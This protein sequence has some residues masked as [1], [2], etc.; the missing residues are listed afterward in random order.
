MKTAAAFGLAAT[1]M[2][3]AA[4]AQTADTPAPA[5]TPQPLGDITGTWAV[6][7]AGLTDTGAVISFTGAIDVA[8][9]GEG[10]WDVSLANYVL[11]TQSQ[12]PSLVNARQACEGVEA[13][14]VVTV[15]CTVT[16]TTA[17][18]TYAP[19]QFTLSRR[20]PTLLTGTLRE[21]SGTDMDGLEALF[22]R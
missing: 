12:A 18:G 7:W 22:V 15:T 5:Q 8:R 14:N 1:L 19:E 6:F 9:A 2:A 11:D 13:N 4:A 20:S 21:S 10:R 16:E 17:G 3:G